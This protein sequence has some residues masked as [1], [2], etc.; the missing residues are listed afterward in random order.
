MF[1]FIVEN[2]GKSDASVTGTYMKILKDACSSLGDV[3]FIKK[4]EKASNKNQYIITDTIQSA[5]SYFAKGYKNHIVW[6][7]GVVPEES[8]MRNHSK[9][10]FIILSA[11][12]KYVIKKAK[13]VLLVSETMQKHYEEK[14]KTDLSKKCVIMP[15]FNEIEITEDAFNNEKYAD[16]TF[17][18]VGSLHAWQCFEQ[19]VE[20]YSKIEKLSDCKTKLYVYTFQKEQAENTIKKYGI[21][22]YIVDYVNK[23]ELS[24]HIKQIKYGFVLRED[25]T[26]NNVATPTK[27]SN[28][29]ANGI[30]PV[31]SSTVKSFASFDEQNKLGIVCNLDDVNLGLKN[32]LSHMEKNILAEDIRLK[33]ENAFA[34]YYN[35]NAYISKISEKL[36]ELIK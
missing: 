18:Y 2:K 31:Y 17:V 25:C 6:M 28:Y 8:Y 36:N 32:I 16:N 26:V 9:L 15:C 29:L 19:T 4:G 21:Q 10:R 27:F 23:D 33:C 12:E 14:Y 35:T 13:L 20:I 5:L 11:L 7:Q 3:E 34:S 22:N 30:I 24:E 1:S